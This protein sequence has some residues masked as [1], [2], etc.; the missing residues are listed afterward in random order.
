MPG[1]GY[2]KRLVYMSYRP[3]PEVDFL[4]FISHSFRILVLFENNHACES[5]VFA[6]AL[7]LL[8]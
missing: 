7:L 8:Y 2:Q 5:H 1:I 4:P 3:L 6:F